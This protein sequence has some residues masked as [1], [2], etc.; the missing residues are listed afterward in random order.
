M[1][2]D[3][4]QE[5]W[6]PPTPVRGAP[7][8][9]TLPGLEVIRLLGAGGFGAVWLCQ[10]RHP[11][12]RQVAVKVMR[13]V[14]A[15]P[16]LR[17]RFEAERRL[18]AKMDHHGI[19]A[20][21]DAGEAQDGSLYFI[22]ELVEGEPILDWCDRN[23]LDLRARLGLMRQVCAAVQHAHTKGIIHLDLKSA[24]ILVR[25]VDGAPVV[26]V[27]DFGVAR[28]ADDPD[29]IPTQLA[30]SGAVGTLEYMAPEQCAGTRQLD[31]RADIYSLGVLAQLLLTGLF[32]FDS[33]QLRAAG[34][35]E[36]QRLIRLVDPEVPSERFA[37]EDVKERAESIERATARRLDTRQLIRLIRGQL[38]AVIL[39]C[40]EKNVNQ[41]YGTCDALSDDLGRW[42]AHEPVLA[43][44]AS[45]PLRVRKFVRRHRIWITAASLIFGAFVAGSIA[46]A[47]GLVEANRQLARAERLRD[48]NSKMIGAVNP[49]IAK[50]MDTRLLR[51]IFEQSLGSIDEDFADDGLLAADAHH[52]AGFAFRSI[53]DYKEALTHLEAQT[54]ILTT[55]LDPEDLELLSAQNDLGNALMLVNRVDDA[56]VLLEGVLEKRRRLLGENDPHTLKSMHNVAWLRDAQSRLKESLALYEDVVARKRVV[57]GPNNDSTLQSLNF[58]GE[59]QRRLGDFP[60]ARATFEDVIARRTEMSG[61]DAPDTLIARNNYLVVIRAL[62]ESSKSE[63]LLR[64]LI[65]DMTR[66]FGAEHIYTL[67]ANN[68]LAAILRD[69]DRLPDAEAIYRANLQLFERRYGP[70]SIYVLNTIGNL[71]LVL[72]MQ[73]QMDEAEPL[74]RD[75]LARKRT[76]LGNKASSTLSSI[77]NL[78][79][80]YWELGR[81]EDARALWQESADGCQDTLGE[82]HPLTIRSL[83]RLAQS[84]LRGGDPPMALELLERALGTSHPTLAADLEMIVMATRGGIL[85]SQGSSAEAMELFTKAYEIAVEI[86]KVTSAYG[87]A[88]ALSELA[89]HHGATEDALKWSLLATPTP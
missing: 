71:A 51:M 36:A 43:R 79:S 2:Q 56:A 25:A 11:L 83:V 10:Q 20:V 27:I 60:A 76:S 55:I 87:Y 9:P 89:A 12:E 38:D 86:K 5:L 3:N 41:R 70:S 75:A 46:M 15:G 28:L 26:K 50:G 13:T 19:A 35:V 64:E 17:E 22:M 52:A 44:P 18:L 37:R 81:F 30:D 66:V 29:A 65:T 48:F 53:G 82:R 62:G 32:P 45:T 63:P 77:L 39:R 42:L 33:R 8:P 73:G 84:R 24:N 31:T 7:I 57:M 78:G 58:L 6:N 16:R 54:A 1:T 80:F 14:V 49:E 23:R 61:K 21:Y 40:L 72:E 69:S 88:R 47:Y 68:N 74:F 34:T 59:V 85:D 67:I 4:S